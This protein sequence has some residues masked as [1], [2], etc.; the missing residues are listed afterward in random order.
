MRHRAGRALA[1]P[2][3]FLALL[4][5][6]QIAATVAFALERPTHNGWAYYQGGDQIWLLSSARLLAHSLL[7]P[8]VVGYGWPSLLSPISA[9]AGPDFLQAMPP[10]IILQ[11][12]ILVP[13]GTVLAYL[14]GERIAGRLNGAVTAVA[15]AAAPF[16]SLLFIDA[17]YEQRWVDIFLPQV[18]GLTAMSD[19]P[20][21]IL[22]LAVAYLLVR[23]FGTWSTTDIAAAGV[24][25][26]FAIGTKPANALLVPGVALAFIV[27]RRLRPAAVFAIAVVPSVAILALWKQRGLGEMPLFALPEGGRPAGSVARQPEVAGFDP[28]R[29]LQLDWDLLRQNLS[30]LHTILLGQPVW[31]LLPV[32]GVV[33]LCRV[34]PPTAALLGGWMGTFLLVKGSYFLSSIDSVSFFR[35]LMPAWAAYVP[36]T[37]A[38]FR[39][40]PSLAR[41]PPRLA[42]RPTGRLGRRTLAALLIGLVGLP[43][44]LV[45]TARPLRD[46]SAAVL[47]ETRLTPVDDSIVVRAMRDPN[48]SVRIVWSHPAYPAS[49]FYRVYRAYGPD[50]TCVKGA[51]AAQCSVSGELLGT[52]REPRFFDPRPAPG[53]TYRLGIGTNAFDDDTAGDVF[54]VSRSIAATP[55]PG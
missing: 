46:G 14:I 8:A 51:G 10:V 18:T 31:L 23:G 26:G 1:Q 43:L 50:P 27:A 35:F 37:A 39:L 32:I 33:L 17:G 44:I 28:G 53:A 19:L 42:D 24:V 2:P 7:P 36:A 9:I 54:V 41:R 4:V 22:L 6:V 48:E 40:A 49:V 12:A 52:T 34:S 3:G 13:L 5:L 15:W 55:S 21:T 20:S 30:D 45:A 16:A 47:F 11:I 38:I 25:A 29:Y